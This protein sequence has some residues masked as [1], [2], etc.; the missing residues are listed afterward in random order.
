[1]DRDAALAQLPE[2]FAVA[3]RLQD[4]GA[5][6]PEIAHIIG[7]DVDAVAAHLDL[8]ESKLARV[9]AQHDER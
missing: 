9:L 1:M 3:L 2:S 5:S 4:R 8:A 7:I 6:D